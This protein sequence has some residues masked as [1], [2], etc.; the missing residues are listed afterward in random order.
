MYEIYIIVNFC[1][2]D[3]SIGA[4]E[5]RANYRKSRFHAQITI[6]T[7]QSFF[8]NDTMSGVMILAPENKLV[9]AGISYANLLNEHDE[10]DREEAAGKDDDLIYEI[11]ESL[12]P[13]LYYTN[14]LE[15]HLHL[16]LDKYRTMG[17]A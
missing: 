13:F 8:E 16:D 5:F 10:G 4:N 12:L 14:K 7:R 17:K 3:K 6:S 1:C 11:Y 15:K 9:N 2:K